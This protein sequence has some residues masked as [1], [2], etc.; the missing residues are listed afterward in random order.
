MQLKHPVPG[1]L[2]RGAGAVLALSL[3]VAA[4][5]AVA[6]KPPAP[7][8]ND[9]DSSYARMGRPAYPEQAIANK[10]SGTVLLRVLVGADGLPKQVEIERSVSALIDQSAVEAVKQWA[11]NPAQRQGKPV[12]GWVLVPITFSLDENAAGEPAPDG[13]LD[14]LSVRPDGEA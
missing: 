10:E 13:A 9:V 7:E 6:G 11:F 5:L 8:P 12:E 4:G 14:T 3:A 2:R 1:R